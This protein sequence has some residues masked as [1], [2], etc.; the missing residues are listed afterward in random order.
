VDIS[1]LR[2]EF[3]VFIVDRLDA[4]AKSTFDSVQSVGYA[5]AHL[6]STM[7]AA[8]AAARLNPPH[9][10]LLDF[11]SFDGACDSFLAD[12]N[13]ISE[14]ILVI[15]AVSTEQVLQA[16]QLV[17]RSTAFDYIAKPYVSSLELIQK[18]DRASARLYFQFESEQLR[19]HY[20]K[21]ASQIQSQPQQ[22][23]RPVQPISFESPAARHVSNTE[24]AK[25]GLSDVNL[26]LERFLLNKE[27]ESTIQIFIEAVSRSLYDVPVLYF[28]YM[29][30]HMSLL[31]SQA[32]LLPSEKFR[33]LGVDLKREDS[34]RL[35]EYFANPSRMPNLRDLIREVFRKDSFSAFAHLNDGEAIGLFVILDETDVSDPN[36]KVRCLQQAF[37]LAYKR[38]LTLKEKHLLDTSDNVTGLYNRRHFNGMLDDEIARSRRLY[39]PLSLIIMDLD[40]TTKLNQ[41]IGFQQTDA[42]LKSIAQILKRTARANDVLA[43]IGP[44]EFACLLPHTGHLGGAVKAERLRRIIEATKVPLLESLGLGPIT[45]SC[46]VSEYPTTSGDADTLFRS[47]D[48]AMHEVKRAGGN[49]VCLSSPPPGFQLDFSPRDVPA[50]PRPGGGAR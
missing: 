9:I 40:G 29:P 20:E 27:L 1:R 34:S 31:F 8:V 18:M 25:P 50:S 12:I 47:A 42:V 3:T 43:R 7:D 33:G 4:T 2:H 35:N 10:V 44:D 48:E 17:G 46:G 21:Q 49:K 32:A 26:A 37:E 24:V 13:A 6:F 22:A 36:S 39:L 16:L 5:E 45:V 14:E 15:L 19:E 28:K 38:N 11:A 30:S 23:P 41:K